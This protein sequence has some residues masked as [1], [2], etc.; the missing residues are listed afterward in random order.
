[1]LLIREMVEALCGV[2][3]LLGLA[4]W[5]PASWRPS[6]LLFCAFFL[7]VFAVAVRYHMLIA[8]STGSLAALAYGLLTWLHPAQQPASPALALEPFLLLLTGICTSDILRW[9]RLRLRALERRYTRVHEALQKAQTDCQQLE[10]AREMLERQVSGLPTSL[11]TISEKLIHL[12]M[13][14]EEQRFSALVD[15]LI[16]VLE[17]QSCA[18]YVREGDR[19]RLCA[20]RMIEGCAHAPVLNREN[21]LVKRVLDLHRV[22][23][24]YDT[25]AQEQ[26]VSSEVAV[27]AGPLLNQAGE[28]TGVVII[29]SIP[30]LRLTPGTARLFGSLLQLFALCLQTAAP[31]TLDESRA[32]H[33]APGDPEQAESSFLA[34]AG[35]SIILSQ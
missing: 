1:V 5:I 7:L 3:G 13:L 11:G 23:T 24:I 29:D 4:W 6:H 30:L 2:S 15:L 17:A 19:W 32:A 28:L 26:A 16:S 12:W 31:E 18:C 35:R 10:L 33:A 25:L 27:M 8:Y 9:Q 22:S 21:P 20:E 34:R 14:K